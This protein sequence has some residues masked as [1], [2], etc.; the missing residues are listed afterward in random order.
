MKKFIPGLV[1]LVCLVLLAISWVWIRNSDNAHTKESDSSIPEIANTA[2][3]AIPASETS[4][5]QADESVTGG[6]HAKTI[7]HVPGNPAEIAQTDHEVDIEFQE[8]VKKQLDSALSGNT[9]DA[10]ATSNLMR[11]CNSGFKEDHVQKYL[12]DFSKMT[13]TSETYLSF[14]DGQQFLFDSLESLEAHLWKKHDQCRAA[15]S[16]F[17]DDL[18]DRIK[19]LADN[20]IVT[21]RYVYALWPPRQS[22]NVSEDTLKL[23]EYQHDAVEYT[24]NN[25]DE[26]EPLGVLAFAQSYAALTPGLFTPSNYMQGLNFLLA[27][28]KCGLNSPW[29]EAEIK[30]KI[31]QRMMFSDPASLEAFMAATESAA[32]EIKKLFC[33]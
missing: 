32:D 14:G 33:D 5:V 4:P 16:L 17:E 27:S 10:I 21:A 23:L 9:E 2:G 8:S 13:F 24:W 6:K 7:A 28:R 19:L 30:A 3:E 31:E 25:T 29:L 20:G 26:R 15:E 12:A 18:R 1:I 11:Q 22:G